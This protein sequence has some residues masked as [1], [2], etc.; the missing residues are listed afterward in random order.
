LQLAIELDGYTHSF[1]KVFEKDKR[2]EQKLN[3]S[4]ITVLRYK[5]VD[6]MNNIENT[7][8]NPLFLEGIE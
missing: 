2:K 8:L 6:V 7:P 4:G 3:E 5:D 1:E